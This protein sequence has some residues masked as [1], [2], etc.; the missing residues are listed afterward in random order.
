MDVFSYH[1]FFLYFLNGTSGKNVDRSPKHIEAGICL[2]SDD[3]FNKDG[4]YLSGYACSKVWHG[5]EA[6]VNIAFA[7]MISLNPTTIYSVL[8]KIDF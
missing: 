8:P 7:A 6:P 5:W 2:I 1:A 3:A 4:S